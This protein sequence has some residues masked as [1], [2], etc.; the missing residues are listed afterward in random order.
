M[1]VV[2]E[3]RIAEEPET[4]HAAALLLVLDYL[5][6]RPITNGNVQDWTGLDP[7]TVKDMM[8]RLR[9]AKVVREGRVPPYLDI[10]REDTARAVVAVCLDAQVATGHLVALPGE[11]WDET[12]YW[13]PGQ[14]PRRE[15]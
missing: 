1:G 6:G 2:R 10:D 11:T 12:R 4:I 7:W 8:R 3:H 15:P 9:A 14:T 5:R 13:L